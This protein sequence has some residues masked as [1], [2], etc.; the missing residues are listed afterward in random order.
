MPWMDFFFTCS[1][2]KAYKGVV[3]IQAAAERQQKRSV[4]GGKVIH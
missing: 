2:S 3:D 4:G 1:Y